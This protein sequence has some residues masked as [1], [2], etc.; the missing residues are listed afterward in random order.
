[1]V[2]KYLQFYPKKNIDYTYKANHYL[3]NKKYNHI[4]S[5]SYTISERHR[6][7][8]TQKTKKKKKKNRPRHTH[9]HTH[10]HTH[11]PTEKIKK[12]RLALHE[13]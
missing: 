8:H 1:M 3:E 5:H 7:T 10:P 6:D 4:N 9:T 12:S 11:K 2:K 13:K